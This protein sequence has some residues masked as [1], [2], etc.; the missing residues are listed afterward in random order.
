MPMK[1]GFPVAMSYR[2]LLIENNATDAQ[3]IEQLLQVKESTGGP[4]FEVVRV[5]TLERGMDR[6]AEQSFAAVLCDLDLPDG[7]GIEGFLRVL[8][9]S[10]IATILFTD[11]LERAEPFKEA[12]AIDVVYKGS[13]EHKLLQRSLLYSMA[14]SRYDS[15]SR[16]LSPQHFL[17]PL[18]AET[19]VRNRVLIVTGA[20]GE[21]HQLRAQVLDLGYECRACTADAAAG[22]AGDY[23]PGVILI[24]AT[25][26]NAR[27]IE[28]C[29]LI[30][31]DEQLGLVP[32]LVI[33]RSFTTEEI[34]KGQ[35]VGVTGFLTRPIRMGE[36]SRSLG[37]LHRL[38]DRETQLMEMTH[39]WQQTRMALSNYFSSDFVENLV[40][41]QYGGEL[42]GSENTASL[43]RFGLRDAQKTLGHHHPRERAELLGRILSDVMAAVVDA[44]GSI[45]Q[46]AGDGLTATFGCP[47]PGTDDPGNCVRAALK[48]KDVMAAVNGTGITEGD[49]LAYGTAAATGPVF[50]ALLGSDHRREFVVMGDTVDRLRGLME[51]ARRSGAGPLVD[52]A[53]REALGEGVVAKRVKAKA[54]NAPEMYLVESLAPEN[55]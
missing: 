24:E 38:R 32:V 1:R 2:V 12:G 18:E 28:D 49:P 44:G 16:S 17:P 20:T 27:A 37:Q 40:R 45:Q 11:D 15:L 23:L 14:R 6:L 35:S 53:T 8:S 21:Q 25:E 34:L 3:V 29:Q 19:N 51:M 55:T 43:L 54:P 30:K 26:S 48:I 31:Q 42:Q 46:L 36:L 52:A 41:Q 13:L 39:Q 9:S 10:G 33:T 47:H 50:A 4:E 22:I 7:E 5:D